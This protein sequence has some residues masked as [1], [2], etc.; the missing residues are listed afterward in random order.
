MKI[1]NWTACVQDRERWKGSLRRPKLSTIKESSAP[2]RR[3]SAPYKG[4]RWNH[5][6][7]DLCIQIEKCSSND[8]FHVVRPSTTSF[9]NM[10]LLSAEQWNK[11]GTEIL[12]CRENYQ[13][14]TCWYCDRCT[15][16]W[17]CFCF[18]KPFWH[19]YPLH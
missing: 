17:Q 8:T 19:A 13:Q 9:Q 15:I 1:K 12:T 14:S 18:N 2:G 7:V 4:L 10:H 11:L 5:Q 3:R 6:N 16:K